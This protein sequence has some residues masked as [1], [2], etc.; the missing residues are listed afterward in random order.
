MALV[1]LLLQIVTGVFLAMHYKSD[2]L[3]AFSTIEY[4]SRNIQNG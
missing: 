4:I 1:C 2:F 3:L